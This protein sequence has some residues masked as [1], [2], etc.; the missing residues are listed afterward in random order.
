MHYDEWRCLCVHFL[1]AHRHTG[2]QMLW[3]NSWF[4]KS[5][6]KWPNWERVQET[7]AQSPKGLGSNSKPRL[8][9]PPEGWLSP[10]QE[11]SKLQPPHL[12]TVHLAFQTAGREVMAVTSLLTC[13]IIT[14]HQWFR[15][16]QISDV[17]WLAWPGYLWGDWRK[18]SPHFLES[19]E[20][21]HSSGGH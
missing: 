10:Q 3:R 14:A 4:Q 11:L 5:F 21:H 8:I 2:D 9:T 16:R 7:G 13:D 20:A 12:S 17:C 19:L 1:G 15:C 18:Q 6:N